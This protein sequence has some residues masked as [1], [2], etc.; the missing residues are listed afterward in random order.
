[1]WRLRIVIVL[2]LHVLF[3]AFA[4]V[5]SAMVLFESRVSCGEQDFLYVLFK[6]RVS[7]SEQDHLYVLF[8]AVSVVCATFAL[9]AWLQRP[10]E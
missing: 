7:C 4:V 2:T 1:M 3:I 10:P 5:S 6:G 9:P 8:M